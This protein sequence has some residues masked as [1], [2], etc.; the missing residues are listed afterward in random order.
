MTGTALARRGLRPVGELAK[1]RPHGDRLRYMAGCRC[2]DCRRANT[3]YETERAAA[4]KA[5]DWNGIVPAEIARAHLGWLSARGVDRRT[6]C[7]VS[8]VADTVLTEIISGRKT[9]IRARTE[10][11]IVAVTPQAAADGAYINAAPT[12]RLLDELIADGY[13]RTALAR[14]L[15]S[16]AKMPSLQ[17]SREQVTV[18]NA[19]DVEKLHARLRCVDAAETVALLGELSEEGFHRDRVARQLRELA[20]ERGLPAPDLTPHRG[21]IRLS[22]ADLVRQLHAQLTE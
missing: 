1:G 5:G 9:R 22:T 19:A 16:T 4:R 15:G 6:V 11:L 13:P 14:A 7:D 17:L 3:R 10:R 21:R 2:A 20:A 18:R 8:G 12:W